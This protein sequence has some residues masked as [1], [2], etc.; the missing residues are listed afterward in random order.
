MNIAKSMKAERVS[1]PSPANEQS[2]NALVDDLLRI[3][4]D[5]VRY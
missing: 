1:K 2:I 4:A 5:P 3:K